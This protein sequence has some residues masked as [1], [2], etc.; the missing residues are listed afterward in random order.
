MFLKTHTL[1][2]SGRFANLRIDGGRGNNHPEIRSPRQ[3]G[4]EEAEQEVCADGALVRLVY[5]DAGVLCEGVVLEAVVEQDV[6]RDV[7]QA[8]EWTSAGLHPHLR[9]IQ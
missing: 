4:L 9:T 5:H 1:V 6:I 2:S 3:G 7:Q 8:G